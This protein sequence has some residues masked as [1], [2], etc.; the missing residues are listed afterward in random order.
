MV[1]NSA[2]HPVLLTNHSEEAKL[3]HALRNITFQI[4]SRR[5][6]GCSN[7]RQRDF[8][9]LHAIDFVSYF[10][11]NNDP[12]H[13]Y[14]IQNNMKRHWLW[15]GSA[16]NSYR[17]H[18]CNV[19]NVNILVSSLHIHIA[20]YVSRKNIVVR[21][22]TCSWIFW[23]VGGSSAETPHGHFGALILY[24]LDEWG[25][26]QQQRLCATSTNWSNCCFFST[27]TDN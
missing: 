8:T 9:L 3:L 24:D 27:I 13:V 17:I 16:P 2:P 23:P 15:Y 18:V 7:K 19:S 26:P 1:N 4:S 25:A 20:K 10:M 22:W 11:Q 6:K 12:I 14:H 21:V 5:T